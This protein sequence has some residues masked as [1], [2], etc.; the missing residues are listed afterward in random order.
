[1]SKGKSDKEIEVMAAIVNAM[2]GRDLNIDQVRRITIWFT[3]RY[4]VED[5]TSAEIFGGTNTF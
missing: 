4:M 5:P 1:M 2:E 3:D